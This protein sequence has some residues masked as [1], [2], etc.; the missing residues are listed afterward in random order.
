MRASVPNAQN[1]SLK[2]RVFSFSIFFFVNRKGS[3]LLPA[4]ITGLIFGTCMNLRLWAA[5]KGTLITCIAFL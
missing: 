3:C 1:N 5:Y 4:E 2:L